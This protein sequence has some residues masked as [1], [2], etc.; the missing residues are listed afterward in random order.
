MA[1]WHQWLLVDTIRLILLL[2]FNH[3]EDQEAILNGIS[4]FFQAHNWKAR[5]VKFVYLS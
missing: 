5:E 2:D 4:S 1:G 3:K